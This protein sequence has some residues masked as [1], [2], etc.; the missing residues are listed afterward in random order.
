MHIGAI[1]FLLCSEHVQNRFDVFISQCP[2]CQKKKPPD[3][4]SRQGNHRTVSMVEEDDVDRH[5]PG[6]G[7]PL[8]FPVLMEEDDDITVEDIER[9]AENAPI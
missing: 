8:S 6:K 3:G 1:N 4:I 9:M 2:Q 5:R 7:L